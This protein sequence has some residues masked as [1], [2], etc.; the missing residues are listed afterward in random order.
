MLARTADN[1]FWTARYMERADFTARVIDATLRIESLPRGDGAAV[2]DEW[3]GAL[4][5]ADAMDAFEGKERIDEAD[6]IGWLAF[7][8]DNPS[9]IR[10]CIET[11]R[12][13]GRAVRT[14][15]TT[16]TWEALN[17]AWLE[18]P[19]FEAE[20]VASRGD[21]GATGRFVEFAKK[22]SL[23]FDGS[24]YRTMLR[25]DAYWFDRLG[26]YVER[27]DNTARLLDVKYHLL[28]PGGERIGGSLD[29]FQWYSILRA[30]SAASSFNW[31]YRRRLE[32]WLVAEM[33]VLRPEMPRSLIGCS[34]NVLRFLDA[35]S[36]DY[37][38]Q[39]P[40][41][42]AARAAHDRLRGAT[43][44]SVFLGGLHEFIAE[45]LDGNAALSAA[46]SAQYLL[47]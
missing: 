16:E 9:S 20:Y 19:K 12:A 5:A 18:M 43:I 30:V 29:Y 28:L 27:G 44:E 35:L 36:A 17:S 22:A 47:G 14:A 34:E 46:I 41:Q 21:R 25:N 6:A 1:L 7:D 33:L 42:R 31:L 38:R 37:G 13:N 24:C 40:A 3:R 8:R 23:D 10:S 15:L 39:G 26:L 11:A 4:A 32:P 2:G 45:F